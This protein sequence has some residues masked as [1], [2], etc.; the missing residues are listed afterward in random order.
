MASCDGMILVL[1]PDE[2]VLLA[3]ALFVPVQF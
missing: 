2:Y 1:L 3:T